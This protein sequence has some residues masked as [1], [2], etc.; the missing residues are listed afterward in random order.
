[1]EELQLAFEQATH[2]FRRLLTTEIEKNRILRLKQV[3]EMQ[4][5]KYFRSQQTLTLQQP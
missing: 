2:G 4:E 5:N 3:T 1:M